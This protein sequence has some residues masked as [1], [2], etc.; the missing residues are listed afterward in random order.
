MSS[1]YASLVGT[2]TYL[3]AIGDPAVQL[4]TRLASPASLREALACTLN[5]AAAVRAIEQATG[6]PTFRSSGCQSQRPTCFR[7][8]QMGHMARL[9]RADVFG[10]SSGN[11]M[12]VPRGS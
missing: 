11:E 9:C 4:L 1:D 3:D 8:H 10:Q 12:E 2:M 6:A 5:V 7:C